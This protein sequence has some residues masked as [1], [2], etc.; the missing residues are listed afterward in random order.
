TDDV[1]NWTPE[2]PLYAH[3]AVVAL[4]AQDIFGGNLLRASLEPYPEFA[5]MRSHYWNVLPDGKEVDFTEPQFLG[6]RPQLVGEPRTRSYVLFD[7]KTGEPREIIQRYKLLAF[8]LSKLRS[9][10]NPLFDDP[11]YASCFS[12]ALDSSCQKMKFGCV[13]A[14]NGEIV[15]RGSNKTIPGLRSLCE[16]ICIRF[17][18]TSRTESMLG[19][20]GHAEEGM[21]E[22]V[23]SGIPLSECEIYIA[24]FF[25]DLYP[26]IKKAR[27]HTCLRCSVQMHNAHLR[28]I[29]VPVVDHWESMTTDKALETARVYATQEKK[30]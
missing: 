21:W 11:I 9:D 6:H 12:V 25:P 13:I 28:A 10:N 23:H 19:A 3:C 20:C 17:S 24:G 8:R 15:Y 29:H 30:V 1:I 22:L 26:W 2:N 7:P 4:V 5:H 14:H 18:I 16:P 27:E